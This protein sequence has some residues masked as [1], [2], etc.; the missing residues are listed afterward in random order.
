MIV[1]GIKSFFDAGINENFREPKISRDLF[2]K[3]LII[4][5]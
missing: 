4:G 5:E 1:G 3:V 2:K